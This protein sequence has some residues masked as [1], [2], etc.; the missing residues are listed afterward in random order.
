[1]AA[2][3]EGGVDIPVARALEH[4][5]GHAVG[6]DMTRRDLQQVA[7]DTRRPWDSG[8]AFDRSAPIGALHPASEIGHPAT[9][10]IW[11]E[12]NGAPRQESDLGHLIWDV[13]ETVAHLS[14]LFELAP[15]DLIYTGTPEGVAAVGPGDTL[16]GGVEGVG[17]LTVTYAA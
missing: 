4:V 14:A 2:I 16:S 5:W 9:G 17:T 15:G 12:V 10:R 13:A 7:K 3:G 6:L 8:K 1:M 11:L